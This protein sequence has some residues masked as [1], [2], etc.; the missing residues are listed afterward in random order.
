M[1]DAVMPARVE[2]DGVYSD[3]DVRLLLG[4]TSATLARARRDGTLRYSRQGN[5]ILYRGG[6]LLAWLERDADRRAERQ[7]VSHV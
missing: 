7:A 5:S 1:S 4:L 6:W 2:A 3:G